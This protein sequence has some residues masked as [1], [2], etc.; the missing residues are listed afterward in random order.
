MDFVDSFC[1]GLPDSL[2]F[3]MLSRT[4]KSPLRFPLGQPPYPANQP[5][6]LE[7]VAQLL[8]DSGM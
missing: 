2:C 7:R 6:A 1:H 8:E 3:S 4:P 5:Y